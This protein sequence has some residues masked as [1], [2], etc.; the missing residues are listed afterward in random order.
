V[1]IN[2]GFERN[3][4]LIG[5]VFASQTIHGFLEIL[6]SAGVVSI[7]VI[8]TD[9]SGTFLKCREWFRN[10]FLPAA[11]DNVTAGFSFG[12]RIESHFKPP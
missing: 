4:T 12:T 7:F 2:A 5:T 3:P 10:H 1:D 9:G 11:T 6:A 8:D